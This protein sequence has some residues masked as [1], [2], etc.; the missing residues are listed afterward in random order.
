MKKIAI[1]LL[2]ISP[3][4]AGPSSGYT[5]A[6]VIN[7]L[8][9]DAQDRLSKDRTLQSLR[10][11]LLATAGVDPSR[12][13]VLD[14]GDA[15][16]APTRDNLAKAMSTF[17]ST[18]GPQDRFLFYYM[19]QA[20]AVTG[21]LRLNLP[22]ADVTHEDVAGWLS[23]IRAGTQLIVLDCPCA[24]LAAKALAGPGRIIV[25]ATTETQVYSTSFGRYFVRALTEPESDTDSD[26]R[27]SALEAFTAAARQIEQWYRDQQILP[28]ETPCLEDNSDGVPSE[29]PWRHTVE[30]VD[31]LAA[32]T[33]FLA[34]N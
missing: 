23:P 9:K 21:K 14:A 28:T 33:F 11:Y 32:S 16:E 8:N 1:L 17:A 13:A 19:G 20:N 5:H 2:L 10:R 27:V 4:L 7:G 22:G 34:E 30:A 6:L 25:C 31:G 18:V 12:L 29:R 26:G 24:G 3:A 15:N